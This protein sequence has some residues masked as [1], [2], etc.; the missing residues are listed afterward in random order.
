MNRPQDHVTE[1]AGAYVLGALAPEEAR[2]I[3]AHARACDQ[4][5]LDI[6]D[7]RQTARLLPLASPLVEP[8]AD[9]RE[10]ILAAAETDDAAHQVLRRAALRRGE[11]TPQRSFWRRPLPAWAGIAGW[12]GV[13]AACIVGGIFIGMADERQRMLA[14]LRPPA[15]LQ[16]VAYTAA[17]NNAAAPA[18]KVFTVNA[19][20]IESEAIRLIGQYEVFD[21]SVGHNGSHIPAKIMQLP[22]ASEAVLVSDLPAAPPGDVYRVWLIRRGK[23]HLGHIVAAGKAVRT[24]IEMKVE[25]GDVIA[26]SMAPME[27][28]AAPSRFFMQ[29]SL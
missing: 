13:A 19:D 15:A 11:Q 1:S 22:N 10:R 8:V 21:L 18:E 25:P 16:R 27:D 24:R 6:A 28:S 7:L 23:A 26:F 3:E 2:A 20:Q 9:L 29:Q 5:R 4:C 14:Q 12:S 17:A